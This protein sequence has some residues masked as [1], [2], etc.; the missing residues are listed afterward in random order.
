MFYTKEEF[1]AAD[2]KGYTVDYFKGLGSMPD[3]VYYEC[4]NNPR[5]IQ[6]TIDDAN[7]LEMMFGDS[8]ELRKNWLLGE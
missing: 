3:D 1:D 5:L 7:K 8:A 6:V 2:L 4:V